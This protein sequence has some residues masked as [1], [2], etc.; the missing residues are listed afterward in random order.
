M[1][2]SRGRGLLVAGLLLVLITWLTRDTEL[3]VLAVPALVLPLL[4]RAWSRV[5]FRVGVRRW[6]EPV[7]V[8]RGETCI[9]A[10]AVTNQRARRSPALEVIDRRGDDEI[11]I[12]VPRLAPESTY[13][14]T[15]HLPTE[16]RG[17]FQLGPLTARR[18]DAFGLARTT[19][20]LGGRMTFSVHPRHHLL[21]EPPGGVRA[22]LDGAVQTIPFGSSVFHGLREYVVG[23][24]HRKIHWLST[25]RTGSPQVRIY[26]DSSVPT[27]S[28]LL[29]DRA[30]KYTDDR[31]EDAVEVA[32]SVLDLADRHE[33]ALVVVTTSGERC[34]TPGERLDRADVLDFLA[35]VTLHPDPAPASASPFDPTAHA[36]A[37]SVLLITGALSGE[38][39]DALFGLR[40]AV[41]QLTVVAVVP[42]DQPIAVPDG[43]AT[44]LLPRA[45]LL[46]QRWEAAIR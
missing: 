13:P 42:D 24:D 10:L 31:F 39:D 6:V 22:S 25:A 9:G 30:S 21:G 26:R 27:L 14:T 8:V 15:Y 20:E 38:D 29:D 5:P 45:D 4:A 33:L 43:T 41:A 23:D 3:L 7:T 2:S 40:A 12:E 11:V 46:P 36:A 17:V 1:L 28:L 37:A 44:I 32:A 19:V 35:R 34:G 16:R 18:G